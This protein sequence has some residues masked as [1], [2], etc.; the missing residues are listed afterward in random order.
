MFKTNK[1][2]YKY[3]VRI[4]ILIIGLIILNMIMYYPFFKVYERN[5]IKLENES[6]NEE[7]IA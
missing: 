4:L 3:L 5:L 6:D 7:A 1:F 2:L